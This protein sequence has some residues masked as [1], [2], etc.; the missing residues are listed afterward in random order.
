[1]HKYKQQIDPDRLWQA[2]EASISAALDVARYTGGPM[3]YPVD[4]MGSPLQ[5]DCLSEFTRHE[6]EEACEFLI[7]MGF[8]EFPKTSEPT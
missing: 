1:M 3:P 4:L 5:P 2:A 6:I 7:R 8:M